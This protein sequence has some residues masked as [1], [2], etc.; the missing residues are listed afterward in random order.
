MALC[1]GYASSSQSI[2]ARVRRAADS[3]LTDTLRLAFPAVF[4][5]SKAYLCF[6]CG[7][8]GGKCLRVLQ[9]NSAKRSMQRNGHLKL[10]CPQ[11]ADGAQNGQNC[12]K[13]RSSGHVHAFAKAVWSLVPDAQ[14]IWD[15]NCVLADARM[16]VDATVMHGHRCSQYEIDGAHHF[17]DRLANRASIDSRKDAYMT[18]QGLCVL[19]LHYRDQ[20]SWV[21]YIEQHIRQPKPF[22]QY[23]KS[24]KHCLCGESE[25]DRVL[26]L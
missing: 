20:N 25:Q 15:W 7:C 23:T 19:R 12:S 13:P 24:Y 1:A 22:V 3:S 14:I 6:R 21:R 16:S 11:C 4:A 9:E 5:P 26:T 8:N 2:R 18:Q 10:S 17:S